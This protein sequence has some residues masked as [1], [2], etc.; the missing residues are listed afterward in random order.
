MPQHRFPEFENDGEW[1]AK[2]GNEIFSQIS[3]KNHNSDLPILAISQE[4]GAIP[5]ELIDYTVIA[6]TKSVASYK[7]IEI[8]DFIISLRSFQGGIEYSK[9][10]GICSPAYIIL[11][12][13]IDISKDFFKQYFKSLPFIADMNRNLEGLRDGK[14]VSYKQFSELLLPNPNPR[15]QQKIASCLSSID[16]LIAAESKKHD[17]FK[18]HKKG[19]MQ[20]LFP[21]DGAKVPQCRFP[22]FENDGDWVVGIIDELTTTLAGNAFKSSDFVEGGIQLMRMG[23]LYRGEIELER[24]PVF[25][26]SSFIKSFPRF[27]INPLDLLMTMTGTIGKRDYGYTIQVPNNSPCLLLNQRVVKI[28]PNNNC[29]RDFLLQLLKSETFLTIL[30]SLPGGTKQVNLSVQQLKNIRISYPFKKS[31]QQKIASCLSSIDELITVQGEKI[32]SL[33]QHKKGL[34]QQLFPKA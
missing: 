12:N 20:K 28:I 34:M 6:T 22:E 3:N 23:N 17:A 24:S 27:V 5:R 33:K 31:E 7:V 4:H 21:T 14:M 9:Y 1:G 15:E 11:R 19:L 8:G 26:P 29:C 13:K 2:N 25:L 10:K 18:D 30:Y 16:D 32:E